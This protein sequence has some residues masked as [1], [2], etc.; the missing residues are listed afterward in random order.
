MKWWKRWFN[1]D[2]DYDNN[3]N[4]N[5]DNGSK[6]DDEAMVMMMVKPLQY[7]L[8]KM[9]QTNYYNCSKSDQYKRQW[10]WWCQRNWWYP[11]NT[12]IY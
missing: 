12:E 7:S 1:Y 6:D 10:D 2:G 11:L 3:D 5:D 4:A 8:A 9:L